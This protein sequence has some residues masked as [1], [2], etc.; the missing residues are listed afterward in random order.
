M[1]AN[2]LQKN[3]K[4]LSKWLGRQNIEC[5]RLYDADM[6]EY[7]VVVDVYGKNAHVAE[8]RAPK[9]VTPE[10]AQQRMDDV[11]AALPRVLDI[12][13]DNIAYKQ[14]TQ[15]KGT[16]Q[17]QKHSSR[18]ELCR[19]REGQAYFLINLFDYLDTGLFLDHRPLRR[20]LFKQC[21]DKDFLNLY[22]YTGS[23]TVQAALGG[24]RSTTS[25][26]TS[27]TYLEWLRK[28]LS[29]NGMASDNH[30]IE[31]A[32]CQQWLAQAG[33]SFDVILVDPPSFSNSKSRETV[34]D[35]QRDHVALVQ[36]AMARLRPEGVLYFSNNRRDFKMD[37][38]LGSTYEC[39]DI[40]VDT[41]DPDFA[42]GRASRHCWRFRHRPV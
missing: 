28:N 11:R 2:R 9:G 25:V 18:G 23:A 16:T 10:A 15:Q 14:R 4:R 5:Y 3:R 24:A 36:A 20:T 30:Q 37:D 31:R 29:Q 8:Y 1:F 12:S 34:F 27:N 41:L 38:S 33:E 39:D 6:P 21:K 32:D 19:V 35:V 42:R 13:P 22:C 26:D 17:Y 40:T 7:A